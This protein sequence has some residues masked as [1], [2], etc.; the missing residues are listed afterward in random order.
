VKKEELINICGH[1]ILST[2]N[3][4]FS[5]KSQFDGIDREIKNKIIS[6]LKELL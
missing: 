1:Y 3:F 4:K 2:D 6:K 5:I